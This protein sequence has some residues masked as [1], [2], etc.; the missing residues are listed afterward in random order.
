VATSAR[1]VE[2]PAC[3]GPAARRRRESRQQ[4]SAPAARP[5]SRPGPSPPPS[6]PQPVDGAPAWIGG[7]DEDRRNHAGPRSRLHRH[8]CAR[9][10]RRPDSQRGDRIEWA[11]FSHASAGPGSG[12]AGGGP[13]WVFCASVVCTRAARTVRHAPAPTG[14]ADTGR[15]ARPAQTG[16]GVTSRHPPAR[17]TRVCTCGWALPCRGP[18]RLPDVEYWPGCGSRGCHDVLYLLSD[19]TLRDCAGPPLARVGLSLR[20]GTVTTARFGSIG[21]TGTCAP[22]SKSRSAVLAYRASWRTLRT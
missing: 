20:G 3:R 22:A 4:T 12:S 8:G 10:G 13:S 7:R 21:G 15:T 14:R 11:G 5:V 2:R 16:Q 17:H 1:H 6:Y 18:A 19:L 9:R